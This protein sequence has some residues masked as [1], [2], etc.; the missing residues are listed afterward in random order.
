MAYTATA[1]AIPM[2]NGAGQ[3]LAEIAYIAVLADGKDS[4]SRPVT[5]A[6]N[7]GPGAASAWLNI[8]TMG[9]WRMS[10]ATSTPSAP[11]LDNR[12]S[13]LPFTDLVFI[14]P[15]GTG[16]SQ[17]LPT[18]K[19]TADPTPAAHHQ[20]RHRQWQKTRE[21]GGP[22][23][24][25]SERGDAEYLARFI[26]TWL[27]SNHR[28]ASP[29]A[30]VG[31]SYGGFRAPKV[32]YVL[33]DDHDIKLDSMVLVSPV[34]DFESRRPA[35]APSHYVHLLP[36][37][38]AT[39]WERQGKS[40]TR[41]SLAETENYARTE[42]IVDL[43]RGSRDHLAIERIAGRMS[44]LTGL[45]RESV[46]ASRA[47]LAARDFLSMLDATTK[48]YASLY[49]AS[50]TRTHDTEPNGSRDYSDPFTGGLAANITKT[51]AELYETRLRWRPDQSYHLQ[52]YTVN[53]HWQWQSSPLSA[54]SLTTM[55]ELLHRN[56]DLRI[57]VTHGFTDLVTPYFATE[58]LLDQAIGPSHAN[59]VS[60]IVYP[61][62]HMFYSRDTSRIA[63]RDD[64]R[65]LLRP[66]PPKTDTS[67]G[68]P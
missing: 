11:L 57:L 67:I 6:F 36:S 62:G 56:S 38:V 65:R 40:V 25:Y 45:P 31:E 17:L 19:P 15:V 2:T 22:S 26:A 50:V 32:A 27:Q 46:A 48:R 63:F 39:A 35:Y 29:K 4:R 23:Y 64:A 18:A 13:W 68:A 7:G 14:D 43:L 5:F 37:Y 47:R 51:M 55:L 59:R 28:L 58:L 10:L 41:L 42:F 9:P 53:W 66:P 52:N 1:G 60:R 3:V 61:G 8:G 33:D 16:Y 49:D 34:L 24:F 30:L 54:Q 21:T 44:E 20:R 12:E